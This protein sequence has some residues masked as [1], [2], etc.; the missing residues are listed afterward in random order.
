MY[1]VSRKE[2]ARAARARIRVRACVRVCGCVCVCTR[3]SEN[4]NNAINRRRRRPAT[5]YAVITPGQIAQRLLING[6]L[7]AVDRTGRSIASAIDG[8]PSARADVSSSDGARESV[9]YVTRH[10]STPRPIAIRR[11]IFNTRLAR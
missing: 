10:V 4:L 11:I 5:N 7:C 1:R 9:G 8:P 2:I 6:A 3:L